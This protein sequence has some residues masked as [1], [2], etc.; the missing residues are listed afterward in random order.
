MLAYAVEF[1][2][3]SRVIG[4]GCN[5]ASATASDSVGIGGSQFPD[6]IF[7]EV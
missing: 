2:T 4:G 7:E 5:T 6:G 3:L 1:L